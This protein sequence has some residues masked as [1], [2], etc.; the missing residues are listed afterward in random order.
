MSPI[1]NSDGSTIVSETCED[2]R[3]VIRSGSA[4]GFRSW[5]TRGLLAT[6]RFLGLRLDLCAR[7][8][9]T[10]HPSMPETNDSGRAARW[11][12]VER[13]GTSQ[14]ETEPPFI[15]PTLSNH[16]LG[17]HVIRPQ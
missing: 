7:L 12:Y 17:N 4:D 10:K 6:I 2:S 13:P 5:R 8:I 14:I 11:H 1:S 16:V 9:G 3:A 15:H